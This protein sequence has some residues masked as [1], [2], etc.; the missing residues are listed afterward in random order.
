MLI[1]LVMLYN[2]VWKNVCAPKRW[3]EGIAVNLSKKEDKAGPIT[4]P[5]NNAVKHHRQSSVRF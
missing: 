4:L 1:M 3:R 5:R 2:W